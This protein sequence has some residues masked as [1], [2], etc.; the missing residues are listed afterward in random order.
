MIRLWTAGASAVQEGGEWHEMQVELFAAYDRA[1][2]MHF[3]R[4]SNSYPLER[5]LAV[6]KA[7]DPP[8]VRA[9]CF[10][11]FILADSAEAYRAVVRGC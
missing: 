6:C 9:R 5:A 4:S 3:L 1:G 8:L 2:L 10:K 7:A 11:W